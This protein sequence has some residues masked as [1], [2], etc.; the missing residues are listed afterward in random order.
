MKIEI[1]LAKIFAGID[2]DGACDASLRDEFLNKIADK[3]SALL[4]PG[5]ERQVSSKVDATA[6]KFLDSIFSDILNHEYKPTSPYGIV[7]KKTTVRNKILSDIEK[8]MVWK[9][10]GYSSDHSLYTK[11][12]KKIME[13][14]FTTFKAE[15]SK[16]VDARFVSECLK[17]AQTKLQERLGIKV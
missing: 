14:K 7:S 16:E 13:E 2:E 10:S 4:L 11:I 8:A 9:D 12:I 5:I 6:Q 3:I 15:F 1:D 17:F